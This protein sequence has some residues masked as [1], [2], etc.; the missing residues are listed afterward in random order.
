MRRITNK[1]D[2]LVVRPR[3]SMQRRVFLA[4]I[5]FALLISLAFFLY[6]HG[7]AM[8]GLDPSALKAQQQAL[9]DEIAMLKEENQTL[10][11]G[12]SRSEL[13]IQMNQTAYGDLDRAL[14]ASAHE[15]LKLREELEFYRN[16]ISPGNQTGGLKIQKLTIVAGSD[17][18]QYNY[19]LV[20]IQALKHER[21]VGGHVRFELDG[22]RQGKPAKVSFPEGSRGI[23]VNFKYF[24][25]IEGSWQLPVGFTPKAVTVRVSTAGEGGV[26]QTFPWPRAG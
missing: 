1:I 14:K 22:D 23:S 12:L 26:E 13:A 7:L 8:A 11:E 4:T 3:S 6:R 24:Q 16:I 10:R 17:N 25:D 15:T 2:E 18:R 19:K 21:N 9:E 5:A 20:L